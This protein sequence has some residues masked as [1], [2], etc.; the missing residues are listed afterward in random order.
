[1]GTDVVTATYS[2]DSNHSGSAGSVNQVVQGGIATTID[3]TNVSP[4]AEDYGL[5]GQVT[6]TAVISWVGNGIAPTASDITN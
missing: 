5:N 3:V 1:V 2:G 4:A 6:I